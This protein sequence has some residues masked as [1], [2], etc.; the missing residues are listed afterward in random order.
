MKY[1]IGFTVMALIA[2]MAMDLKAQ[3]MSHLEHVELGKVKWYRDYDEATQAAKDQGKDIVVLFQEV[4]GCATCRNYGHNVLTHPLMVEALENSFI[5]LT[6]FNN[7]GGDDR[8]ILTKYKEPTWNNP[9]VRIINSDGDNLINRIA[10]DY[11]AKAL[12]NSMISVLKKQG[13]EVPEYLNLLALELS[14]ASSY[15]VTEKYFQM[16]CFWTGEKQLGQIDGVIDTESGFMNHAE[17]VKIK[18]DSDL[19]SESELEN[20]ANKNNMRPVDKK[21]KYSVATNDV[22]YYLKNSKYKYIPLTELQ[23]TKINSALGNRNSPERYLSPKQQRWLQT[24]SSGSKNLSDVDFI[25]AWSS[26]ES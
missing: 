6:I 9:V 24:V 14:T 11:S 19:V 21:G 4:P 25:D 2:F 3:K 26:K 22:H 5:P 10:G 13:K 20:F 16:Y 8:K 12:C 17:V 23:K 7:K 18:Y 15:Q 1:Q